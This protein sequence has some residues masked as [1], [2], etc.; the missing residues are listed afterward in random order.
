MNAVSACSQSI[1]LRHFFTAKVHLLKSFLILTV[2]AASFYPP[3]LI[4]AVDPLT[5]I[6]AFL[7]SVKLRLFISFKLSSIPAYFSI[8]CRG[9]YH[10]L[11]V[12]FSSKLFNFSRNLINNAGPRYPYFMYK[13]YKFKYAKK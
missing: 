11:P 4:D 10:S 5:L 3:M 13:Q 12:K 1:S 7:H 9:S 8:L 6:S 2:Y